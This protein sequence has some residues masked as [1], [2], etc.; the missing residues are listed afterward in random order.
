MV[1]R[2]GAHRWSSGVNTRVR[3]A[4][5]VTPLVAALKY[6]LKCSAVHEMAEVVSAAEG[7]GDEGEVTDRLALVVAAVNEDEHENSAQ[8][9]LVGLSRLATAASQND[10]TATLMWCIKP[11][12]GFRQCAVMGGARAVH[13]LCVSR[14]ESFCVGS[15]DVDSAAAAGES[16]GHGAA[17]DSGL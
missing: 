2:L 16:G 4:K 8:S 7:G 9:V 13:R 5:L 10:R 14:A 3:D 6:S 11:G 15:F 17:L 1:N 12:H